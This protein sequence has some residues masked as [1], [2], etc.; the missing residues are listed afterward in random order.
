MAT[1]ESAS[2]GATSGTPSSSVPRATELAALAEEPSAGLF[3]EKSGPEKSGPEKATPEKTAAK[4]KPVKGRKAAATSATAPAAT[5]TAA[6]PTSSSPTTSATTASEGSGESGKEAT[7]KPEGSKAAPETGTGT[8]AKKAS[9]EKTEAAAGTATS[10]TTALAAS[11][12]TS[13][14]TGRTATATIPRRPS[15]LPLGRPG[16]PMIAAALAG[17][18]LLVGVPFLISGLS[19]SD[20]KT[21]PV[22][23]EAP[24]GS[25]M[26]PD[27]TGPGLVPGQQNAP[28]ENVPGTANAKPG[29]NTAERSTGQGG[30]LHEGGGSST[31]TGIEAKTGPGTT[32]AEKGTEPVPAEKNGRPAPGTPV[33]PG[34]PAG[35]DG[36]DKPADSTKT[37]ARKPAPATYN[38]L[39]GPGCDTPG[40]ATSDQY[41]DSNKGWRGSRGSQTAYGCSG[42]YYSLPLSNSTSKSNGVFAQ[43]KFSTGSVET[44]KCAVSVYVP[45]VK[46]IS[47]VGGNPAHYTVHRAFVPKSSTKVGTFEINQT[48]HLGQWVS[49]GTFPMSAGKISIVLDNR[50]KTSGNRHAAA[51]PVKV[52]CTAA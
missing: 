9:G 49:A 29:G 4:Q 12:A 17:G 2:A 36:A 42:F 18:L 40:F 14:S 8:E 22:S 1:S 24:Q 46:D 51:A 50:G 3:P 28:G 47:Y 44:G 48:A 37:N 23:A 21:G 20:D 19:G 43:W 26:N 6:V 32:P 16:K 5:A 38:H 52:S 15:G 45:N 10:P 25:R 30:G 31:G 34:V 13:T 11:A 39:V 35:Q 7:A 41:R 27:G 33:Q